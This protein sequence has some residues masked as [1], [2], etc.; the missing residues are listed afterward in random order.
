ML[1][2]A[3]ACA[4]RDAHAA[5]KEQWASVAAVSP[6]PVSPD[7]GTT[8]RA[9]KRSARSS[10]APRISSS[11]SAFEACASQTSP[12]W[13]QSGGD[14]NTISRPEAS[15]RC[16]V[17]SVQSHGCSGAVA[18]ASWRLLPAARVPG[19]VGG[20]TASST[21]MTS[22]ASTGAANFV[23]ATKL[24]ALVR[25]SGYYD[26]YGGHASDDEIAEGADRGRSGPGAAG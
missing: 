19:I 1:G 10:T 18:A 17:S 7:Q 25:R 5:W 2:G 16:A 15:S 9:M 14:V 22:S 6:A 8:N 21:R 4:G 13:A 3:G 24:A 26:M 20:L 11:P 23:I 12:G